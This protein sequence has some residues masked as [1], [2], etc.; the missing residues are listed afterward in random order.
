MQSRLLMNDAMSPK[1]SVKL[2]AQQTK[3][4][5]LDPGTA[6]VSRRRR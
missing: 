5:I 4:G 6:A 3:Y 1:H 2:Q